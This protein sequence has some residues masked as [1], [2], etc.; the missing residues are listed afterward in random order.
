VFIDNDK[1]LAAMVGGVCVVEI[2][3]DVNDPNQIMFPAPTVA[4][5]QIVNPSSVAPV[6]V[7]FPNVIVDAFADTDGVAV[8]AA[9]HAAPANVCRA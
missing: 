4:E 8:V 7:Q 9:V 2:T 3:V 5:S 6:P 1:A